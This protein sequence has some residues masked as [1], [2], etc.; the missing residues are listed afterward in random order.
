MSHHQS[1]CEGDKAQITSLTPEPEEIKYSKSGVPLHMLDSV[2][3]QEL[4]EGDL[5]EDI[6]IEEALTT[7]W[8]RSMNYG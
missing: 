4:P 5:D 6:G 1:D 8:R 2:Q 7:L 3:I